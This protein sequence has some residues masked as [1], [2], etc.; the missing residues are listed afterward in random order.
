MLLANP[1]LGLFAPINWNIKEGNI[2]RPLYISTYAV[3]LF[4]KLIMVL[5]C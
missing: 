4:Q 2:F 5:I 1:I 3:R